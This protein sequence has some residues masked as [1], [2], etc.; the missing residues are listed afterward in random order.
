MGLKSKAL[1]QLEILATIDACGGEH[2][3][4]D[5]CVGTALEGAFAIVSQYA[6]TASQANVG[7]RV[8]KAVYG[9][10]TGNGG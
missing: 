8:D 3:I 6:A 2:V 5:G 10:D 9:H 1:Y 7:L 4:G